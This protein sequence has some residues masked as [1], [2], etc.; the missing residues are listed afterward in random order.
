MEDNPVLSSERMSWF[1][2]HYLGVE[3]SES[4]SMA[5]SSTISPIRANLSA[6][7]PTFIAVAEM[8]ILRDE[9]KAYAEKLKASGVKTQFECYKKM[10]HTFLL[11]AS[12]LSEAKRLQD[13]I[14]A[15]F[16]TVLK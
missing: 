8:D 14:L 6:L 5:K 9:G 3:G 15:A 2:N 10:P 7:P 13:D 4:R 1:Y 12:I 11:Y 16:R